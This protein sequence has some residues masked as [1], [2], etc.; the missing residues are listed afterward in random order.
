M[1]KGGG[2]KN[3]EFDIRAVI[4][5][6]KRLERLRYDRDVAG[7]LGV[8]AGTVDQWKHRNSQPWDVL[9]RYAVATG[10][11][12]DWLLFGA[13][14]PRRPVYA[15]LHHTGIH[16]TPAGYLARVETGVRRLSLVHDDDPIDF[17]LDQQVA[18]EV[19]RDLKTGAVRRTWEDATV[20]EAGE[21]LRYLYELRYRLQYPRE[22][23]TDGP[24]KTGPEG[25]P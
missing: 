20:A 22:G 13:G 19:A 14:E 10:T 3:L 18:R 23:R 7:P 15:E 2:V 5:R 12:L 25:K 11:S 9:A 8:A 6:V 16:E 17:A 21:L 4:G 1:V 24:A